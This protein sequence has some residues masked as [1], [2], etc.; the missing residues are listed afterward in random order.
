MTY[1]D[2]RNFIKTL[3]YQGELKKI[4]FPV[5]PNLEITEIAHRTLKSQGPALLFTNPIGHSIPILCN[6]FGTISR[7]ELGIGIKNILSLRD[8][9][10]LLAFLKEPQIPT[11]FR[12]FL[13][14]IPNFRQILNMPIKH[15]SNAVCQE[16]IWNNAQDIDITQMPIMKSWPGDISIA[17][18]WGITITQ[19]FT[20][21]RQNL[22][23]YR[24]QVLSKNKIIIRWLAHRGGALDF[25]E[26]YTHSS[27]KKFPIAIALGADPATLIGAAIPIP[28]TLSEYAFS[29]LLRGSKTAVTKCISSNL[30]VPA[31]SEIILEGYI[32]RDDIAVEGPFGDHT[33]YY[34]S[35]EKFPVCTI[36]H[37]THRNNPIYHSTY[38]GRPPDEPSILG[39]AM[40]ELFIPIIQKQFP[41]IIDFYLPPE[42]CSYRLAIVTIK[43]QF[44]G[45]AKKIIFGVWSCLNQFMYT[46]F[47]LVCDDDINARDW[48]DVIWAISTRMDPARDIII[49]ENTPIDYLDF[50]SP[51]SGLGSKMGIDATNKWPGE[52]QRTWGKPIQMNNSIQ[53]RIN[54]IWDQLHIPCNEKPFKHKN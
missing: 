21:K 23:I 49:A 40:N 38:T 30:Y 4:D 3:E 7:I 10:K 14:K 1:K 37:I 34:N 51:I 2:L 46:K 41:E 27:E 15:V 13:S 31:Y 12:D 22:G 32:N 18:T 9:G 44:L 24:H 29:G 36:T 17:I 43:K 16:N 47:I 20:N 5:D 50:S 8:I 19:G 53:S 42:G 6:L 26:W 25:Q 11:G 54:D 35:T 39:M 45:H 33:G 52:T 28:N 48:K